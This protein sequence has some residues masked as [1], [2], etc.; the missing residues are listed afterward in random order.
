MSVFV[1]TSPVSM[2]KSI[3]S[4]SSVDS[5]S[6]VAT[7]SPFNDDEE[8]LG[9][10]EELKSQWETMRAVLLPQLHNAAGKVL[11][12]AHDRFSGRSLKGPIIVS[13]SMD[14]QHFLIE[15]NPGSESLRIHQVMMDKLLGVG[16]FGSVYLTRSLDH[17]ESFQACKFST[18]DEGKKI[19]SIAHELCIVRHLRSCGLSE[20]NHLFI[21]LQAVRVSKYSTAHLAPLCDGNLSEIVDKGRVFTFPERIRLCREMSLAVKSLH[22][23]GVVHSDVKT[24]NFFL[25]S[26]S[27]FLADFGS[28]RILSQHKLLA[29]YINPT[30]SFSI[31]ENVLALAQLIG[32]IEDLQEAIANE[33]DS[34]KQ[35]LM[36]EKMDMY[37]MKY[38]DLGFKQDNIG[39][40]LSMLEILYGKIHPALL[41]LGCC[42]GYRYERLAPVLDTII[43]DIHASESTLLCEN[44][45]ELTDSIRRLCVEVA[46]DVLKK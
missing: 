23:A 46:P 28:A 40:L 44:L 7:N 45:H 41:Q 35:S 42:F 20:K 12:V 3:D 18:L 16:S 8:D 25:R 10:P 2:L 1:R 31:N 29:D 9:I 30:M 6:T 13:L 37:V 14:E 19:T 36:K 4:Q 34:E 15:K 33:E 11:K 26:D 43:A 39:L 5:Q 22:E 38:R 32:D 27:A 24:G 17:S 21:Q